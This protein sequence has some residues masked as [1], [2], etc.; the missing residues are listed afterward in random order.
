[1]L[2]IMVNPTSTGRGI[3]RKEKVP[4]LR[5]GLPNHD[6]YGASHQLLLGYEGS[7]CLVESMANALLECRE[8]G[9]A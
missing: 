7:M 5:V 4:L 6:R 9:S 1:M 3:A 2:T 8:S